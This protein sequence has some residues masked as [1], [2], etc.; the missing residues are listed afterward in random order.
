MRPIRCQDFSSRFLHHDSFG[1]A[2]KINL[3]RLGCQTALGQFVNVIDISACQIIFVLI[4]TTRCLIM[5][6]NYLRVSTVTLDV[7]I[8]CNWKTGYCTRNKLKTNNFI[9]DR[10]VKIYYSRRLENFIHY[11]T[12]GDF[13]G[14]ES[15]LKFKS[16]EYIF[17]ILF[18]TH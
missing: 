4:I 13:S 5:R 14:T 11:F 7:Y 6:N 18:V 15:R 1:Y 17:A 2:Q 16:N 9:Y 12:V 8:S 10:R 3:K